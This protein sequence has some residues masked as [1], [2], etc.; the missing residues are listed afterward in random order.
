MKENEEYAAIAIDGSLGGYIAFHCI[1][2]ESDR[3]FS[4]LCSRHIGVAIC[5]E[6]YPRVMLSECDFELHAQC[7]SLRLPRFLV[8]VE[9][10]IVWLP[11][12]GSY[13]GN[14]QMLQS[15]TKPH[16]RF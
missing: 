7:P 13:G 1:S 14:R 6:D 9:W 3:S 4:S 2:I 15:G 10:L 16:V 5:F 11:R 12:Q 8:N